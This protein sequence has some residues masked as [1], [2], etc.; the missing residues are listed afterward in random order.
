MKQ[1][2]LFVI[3]SQDSSPPPPPRKITLSF[4]SLKMEK[5]VLCLKLKTENI[6]VNWKQMKILSKMSQEVLESIPF[7]LE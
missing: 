7:V 5:I 1:R 2:D 4:L 3:F 6:M